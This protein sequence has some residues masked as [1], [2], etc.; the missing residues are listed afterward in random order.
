MQFE[1]Q[2]GASV[3]V[4]SAR[5]YTAQSG[6]RESSEEGE[7]EISAPV[8]VTWFRK[9]G[10]RRLSTDAELASRPGISRLSQALTDVH[11][12]VSNFHLA[13]YARMTLRR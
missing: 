8:Q 3:A 1:P 9:M 11:S 13:K 2:V 7:A 12:F 5:E 6:S 10:V 4:R